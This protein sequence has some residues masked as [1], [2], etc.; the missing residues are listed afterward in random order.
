MGE[1]EN[2]YHYVTS[3]LKFIIYEAL[4]LPLGEWIKLDDDVV[5]IVPEEEVL[6]LSGGG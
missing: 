5:T 4:L 3:Y 1:T 6:K 2:R